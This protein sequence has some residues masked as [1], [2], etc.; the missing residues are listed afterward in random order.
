VILFNEGEPAVKLSGVFSARP[1]KP[2]LAALAAFIML[3]PFPVVAETVD[4]IVAI[5]NDSVITMS[6][7]NAATNL[8][9][10]KSVGGDK[11]DGASALAMKKKVLDDLIEQKLVKQASDKA[12]IDVSE[13]E[14][15]NAVEDIKRENGMTQDALL[16]TL[17][18]TGLTFREYREQLKEQIRQV[19]FIN[20]E[21]RSKI[22]IEPEDVEDYYRQHKDDF[23]TPA[24]YKISMIFIPNADKSVAAQKLKMI[25]DGLSKR[26]DFKELAR[27]YSEGPTASSGGDMGYLKL[28]EMDKYV[29]DAV[30][31]LKANEI[32]PA[33]QAADGIYF[34][35]LDDMLPPKQKPFEEVKGLAQD[36]L[37]R[38]IM[39][40]R[41][42][43]WL[44]EVKK[45]AHVEIRL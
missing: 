9:L 16:L 45:Y 25:Q 8:A 27:D 13:K 32:S 40:D 7:L 36:K 37:Y 26:T 31:K 18:R 38:K 5:I 4:R 24:A 23:Q 19:K 20:K 28:S 42:S 44:N 2:V 6:E 10:E 22:T 43:F 39:D 14:I 33:I 17:A 1:F 21:F 15:D 29:Q 41:F 11:L 34:I 3:A 12:G 35:Q 30:I